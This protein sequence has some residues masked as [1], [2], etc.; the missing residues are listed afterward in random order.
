M[1]KKL[2][3]LFTFLISFVM[4]SNSVRAECKVLTCV[5]PNGQWGQDAVKIVQNSNC[6]LEFYSNALTID[7]N[8][9]KWKRIDMEPNNINF[10]N[11]IGVYANTKKEVDNSRYWDSQ[12]GI[13][14]A[15]PNCLDYSGGKIL[16]HDILNKKGTACQAAGWVS[17]FVKLEKQIDNEAITEESIEKEGEDKINDIISEGKNYCRYYLYSDSTVTTGTIDKDKKI[18][19]YYN[20]SEL[21]VETSYSKNQKPQLDFKLEDFLKK[22]KGIC[23]TS[24]YSQYTVEEGESKITLKKEL[25][26][27]REYVLEEGKYINESNATIYDTDIEDPCQLIGDDVLEF[28]NDIMNIIRIG[29]PILLLVFGITD[30][31]RATFANSEDDIKKRRDTFIKR[32][33]AAIIVFIIPIFVNLVLKLGNTVWSDIINRETCLDRRE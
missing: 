3:L 24:L 6:T 8:D 17:D 26:T 27:T 10:N 11:T 25:K 18:K 9:Q 5:Y 23:P 20:D 33:I 15:C 28:I 32:I 30:F 7:A 1:K 4:F 19:I 21:E 14:L 12:N 29:V 13:L 2:F 16:A 31:F 22:G